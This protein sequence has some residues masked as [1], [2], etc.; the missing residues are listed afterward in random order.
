[1][2]SGLSTSTTRE[3]KRNSVQ[4]FRIYKI[5]TAKYGISF[6]S[7]KTQKNTMKPKH[8]IKALRNLIAVAALP[9]A[10]ML[11]AKADVITNLGLFDVANQNPDTITALV[12]ASGVDTGGGTP[13]DMDLINAGRITPSGLSLTNSF[14]T[15]T[16]ANNTTNNT[17]SLTFS[18]NSGFVL[19]GVAVHA[20]GGS[21][22]RLFSIND[23]TA[24]VNE[25]PFFGS[26]N[27]NGTNQGLSNFDVFVE[28]APVPEPNSMALYGVGAIGL[29]GVMVVRH[30]RQHCT[31]A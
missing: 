14:G 8:T 16:V 24:G 12:N 3:K 28:T 25:G 10:L 30:R 29:L 13:D 18:L 6:P 27:T 4:F 15:F 2:I 1:V 20:G 11:S 22:D 21:T 26:Q 17:Q 31:T 9:G 5:A 23:E 7:P 19:A